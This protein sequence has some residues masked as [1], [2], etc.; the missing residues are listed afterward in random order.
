MW[1]AVS[2]APAPVPP[3][4]L[5]DRSTICSSPPSA[6]IAPGPRDFTRAFLDELQA[7]ADRHLLPLL[8]QWHRQG[9]CLPRRPPVFRGSGHPCP[10]VAET[11]RARITVL[12]KNETMPW[13]RVSRRMAV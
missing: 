8:L 1:P 9:Y 7:S 5:R 12:K 11:A 6:S 4:G 10:A 2:H 13:A 3:R